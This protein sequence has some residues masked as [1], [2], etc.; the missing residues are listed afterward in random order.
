MDRLREFVKKIEG[1]RH[2][3]ENYN[4]LVEKAKYVEDSLRSFNL[5]VDNQEVSFNGRDYRNITATKEGFDNENDWILLGAHYDAA[6]GSP[7]ADD[8]A[9]GVAV[10]LEAA[11]IISKLKLNKNV[12]FSAFTLEEPQPQTIHFLIG[13]DLFAKESKRLKRS[14]KAVF[15]LESVGYTDN[16]EGSQVTPP[17]VRSPVPKKGNFLGVIANRKSQSIMEAFCSISDQY[18]PELS[19]VP[20]KV[21]FNGRIIPE[22]RFSDHASFWD[23]GYPALMLT[24]TAM[25]RNPHYHT[26]HDRYETLDFDFMLNVTKAVVSVI[27][28]LANKT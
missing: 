20:Y 17:F 6:S 13:S 18:V 15:I 11:N 14:Y 10:L 3:W 19:V 16:E 9:S 1:L 25:F 8:N 5:P 23:Q 21:P 28:R 2:G 4:S 12:Q 24:D 22:T 27:L 26:S 7:G